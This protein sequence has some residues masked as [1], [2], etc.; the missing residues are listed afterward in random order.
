MIEIAY[1]VILLQ[2]AH[3]PHYMELSLLLLC[4]VKLEIMVSL[5]METAHPLHIEKQIQMSYTK[6]ELSQRDMPCFNIT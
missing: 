1:V 4:S 2:M 6:S 3:P 5:R